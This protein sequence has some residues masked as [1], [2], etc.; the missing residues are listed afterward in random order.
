M[1][2]TKAIYQLKKKTIVVQLIYEVRKFFFFFRNKIRNKRLENKTAFGEEQGRLGWDVKHQDPVIDY[3]FLAC[4]F[5]AFPLAMACC[6]SLT[7][8]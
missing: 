3:T 2:S 8:L 5:I 7:A 6:L 1:L 4:S